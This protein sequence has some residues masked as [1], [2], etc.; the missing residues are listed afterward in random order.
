MGDSPA[1]SAMLDLL[2]LEAEL[3]VGD[4]EPY[5]MDGTDYTA[6]FHAHRRGR[7]AVELE[8]RQDLLRDAGSARA[9]AALF[10]RL[11]PRLAG[12]GD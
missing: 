6:P 11:L 2:R 4:N 8:V 1:S 3:V 7:D 5:A 9:I 12:K 10:V